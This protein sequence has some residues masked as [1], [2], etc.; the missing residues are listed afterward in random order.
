M[1]ILEE[2]YYDELS[3]PNDALLSRCALV[4]KQWSVLAQKLLF[5]RVSLRSE[6]AFSSFQHAVDGSTLKGRMLGAVVN[7]MRVV[8][9]ANHPGALRQR[10]FARA[11]TLCPNLYELGI[12]LYGTNSSSTVNNSNSN[13]FSDSASASR[14]FDLDLASGESA[15]RSQK[16]V[17]SFD[18]ETLA[19]LR[20][21]P[22]ITA[23][24]FSNWTPNAGALAELLSVWHTSLA[25]LDISGT[26][27]EAPSCSDSESDLASESG[28]F[29]CALRSLRTNFQSASSASQ[30][31]HPTGGPSVP[32]MKWLLQHSTQTL[33]IL[34]FTRQ[35]SGDMLEYVADAHGHALR[36]LA[37]PTCVRDDG[38]ARALGRCVA[39]K[40]LRTESAWVAPGAYRAVSAGG[41]QLEHLAFG[42]DRDTQLV[43]VLQ[44]IRRGKTLRV[45]SVMLWSGGRGSSVVGRGKDGVCGDGR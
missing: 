3:E 23:L 2:A 21:G 20:T 10:S 29:E 45:V 30:S 42:V 9:D 7:Y 27:P 5:R 31:V 34:E 25:Y 16:D 32:F 8:L 28:S 40:E 33:E 1:T 12:S 4:N 11:V 22:A 24:A 18:E 15:G 13:N 17:S 38:A 26:P 43:P 14:G 37:L 36:S 39:L 6:R 35:P 44:A 41:L 19:V